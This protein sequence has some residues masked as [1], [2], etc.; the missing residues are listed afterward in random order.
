VDSQIGP[1]VTATGHEGNDLFWPG[2]ADR[3]RRRRYCAFVARGLAGQDP[4][5]CSEKATWKMGRGLRLARSVAEMPFCPSSS[6]AGAGSSSRSG[7]GGDL[8]GGRAGGVDPKPQRGQAS[9]PTRNPPQP[10]QLG[11]ESSLQ[12]AAPVGLFLQGWTSLPSSH[13]PPRRPQSLGQQADQGMRP[14]RVS[15]H[16]PS[17]VHRNQDCALPM[18]VKRLASRPRVYRSFLL[19][20]PPPE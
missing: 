7:V 11:F 19:G 2:A 16:R 6:G 20:P 12:R 14:V 17:P 18:P 3:S 1:L 10:A 5:R 15:H 4:S 13:P 9:P 8:H